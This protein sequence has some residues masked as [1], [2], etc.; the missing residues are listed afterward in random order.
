MRGWSLLQLLSNGQAGKSGADLLHLPGLATITVGGTGGLKITIWAILWF[1]LAHWKVSGQ[2]L[3][4]PLIIDCGYCVSRKYALTTPGSPTCQA[5]G[6][7]LP[8]AKAR[9]RDRLL[10]FFLAGAAGH[11]ECPPLKNLTALGGGRESGQGDLIDHSR[12]SP[13]KVLTH[14]NNTH[15]RER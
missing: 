5:T 14:N 2:Y 1:F 13:S 15:C 11:K 7:C 12:Q 6:I 4:S 10:S 9:G 8:A 3:A